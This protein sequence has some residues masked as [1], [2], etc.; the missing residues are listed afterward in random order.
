MKLRTFLLALAAS[1][2]GFAPAWSQ[3]T[4]SSAQPNTGYVAYFPVNTGTDVEAICRA[5]KAAYAAVCTGY[6]RLTYTDLDG[7]ERSQ[8]FSPGYVY[9]DASETLRPLKIRVEILTQPN[10]YSVVGAYIYLHGEP[11]R[12]DRKEGTGAFM[13]QSTLIF[14]DPN[15]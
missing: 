9:V 13:A 3:D 6:F 5:K 15:L 12:V 14:L 10:K 11:V 8:D 7:V 4:A 2:L 1:L